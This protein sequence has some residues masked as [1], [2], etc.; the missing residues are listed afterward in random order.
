MKNYSNP[1]KVSLDNKVQYANYPSADN[2]LLT[3]Q[4]F[5]N[6]LNQVHRVNTENFEQKYNLTLS[7]LKLVGGVSAFAVLCAII[8]EAINAKGEKDVQ[9]MKGDSQLEVEEK[10]HQYDLDKIKAEEDAKIRIASAKE[11]LRQYREKEKSHPVSEDP[12]SWTRPCD[13]YIAIYNRQSL[14]HS[15]TRYD[16]KPI[17]MPKRIC[18]ISI[19]KKDI[20]LFVGGSGIGK[21][22]LAMNI[23]HCLADGKPIEAFKQTYKPVK[24]PVFYVSSERMEEAF[25]QRFQGYH[26]KDLHYF[27]TQHFERFE[28]CLD[29]ICEHMDSVRSDCMF[30]FDHMTSLIGEQMNSSRVEFFIK[31]LEIIQEEFSKLGK[32]PTFLLLLHPT[33]DGEDKKSIKGSQVCGSAHWIRLVDSVLAMTA[34]DRNPRIRYLQQKKNRK[35]KDQRTLKYMIEMK[36]HPVLHFKYLKTLGE[37]SGGKGGKV[38]RSEKEQFAKLRQKGDSFAE[39]ARK[40]KRDPKTIRKHIYGK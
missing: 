19:H 35:D 16:R 11:E 21:S 28:D 38:Y 34:D 14:L 7:I 36:A 8:N 22:Q 3:E 17:V 13:K 20:A 32:I 39:I 25:N 1:V 2:N 26:P 29:F 18:G 37:K 31:V 33:K 6:R 30:T 27:D 12:N 10:R 9:K 24:M 15:E 4:Q 5:T 23:S 40:T